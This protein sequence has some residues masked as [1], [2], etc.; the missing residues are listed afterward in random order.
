[1]EFSKSSRDEKKLII[2]SVL[3]N[4]YVFSHCMNNQIKQ[5]RAAATDLILDRGEKYRVRTRVT[6]DRRAQ[7]VR[8]WLVSL[9]LH[10]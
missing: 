10:Q 8:A 6:A 2:G 3:N 7:T 9:G 5:I 4:D 1:M